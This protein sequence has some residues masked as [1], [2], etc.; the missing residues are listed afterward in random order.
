MAGRVIFGS[1]SGGRGGGKSREVKIPGINAAVANAHV[2]RK[3]AQQRKAA[4]KGN[5]SAHGGSRS[6]GSPSGSSS[7]GS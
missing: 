6:A 1:Q 2:N 3:L 4:R 7:G 5:A